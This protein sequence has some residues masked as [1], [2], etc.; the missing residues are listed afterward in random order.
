MEEQKGK[1]SVSVNIR[2]LEEMPLEESPQSRCWIRNK[3]MQIRS[4]KNGPLSSKIGYTNNEI[5]PRIRRTPGIWRIA[6]SI[7]QT[8]RL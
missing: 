1:I 3:F 7:V 6:R 8:L 4:A 5:K 2:G